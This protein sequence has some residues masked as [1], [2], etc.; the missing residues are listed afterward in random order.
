MAGRAFVSLA[1]SDEQRKEVESL[2]PPRQVHAALFG[3]VK[4]VTRSGRTQIDRRVRQEI[5]ITTKYTGR[6][7]K[8]HLPRGGEPVGT[9]SISRLPIPLIAYRPR[10]SKR[11]GVVAKVGK[12]HPPVVYRHGFRARVKSEF[13]KAQ[14]LEGHQGVFFRAKHLPT[15]G[16]NAGAKN[17]KGE[18]MYKL[19]PAGV[20]GRFA[21]KEIPGPSVLSVLG[22]RGTTRVASEELAKLQAKLDERVRSKVDRFL[23]RK[24]ADRPPTDHG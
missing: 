21:V 6:A 23:N 22:E 1:V 16:P 14:G 13:Q 9:I 10:V 18:P 15:K 20:A 4:E 5:N 12:H 11:G 7:I 24:K 2:L 8:A 19:T 3:A 17:K